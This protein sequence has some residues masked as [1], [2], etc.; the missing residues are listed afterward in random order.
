MRKCAGHLKAHLGILLQERGN[1][2]TAD[3]S[4]PQPSG[5][6]YSYRSW[7]GNFLQ[8]KM[9][10]YMTPTLEG[11]GNEPVSSVSPFRMGISH[12]PTH[13]LA[14]QDRWGLCV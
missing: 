3:N 4:L 8:L 11:M 13:G 2:V 1:G 12:V 5:R 9:S 6:R 7:C 10:P 14:P